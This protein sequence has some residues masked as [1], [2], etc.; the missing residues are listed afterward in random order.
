VITEQPP[1]E[2]RRFRNKA[3]L[4]CMERCAEREELKHI[5]TVEKMTGEG[6]GVDSA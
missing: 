1:R 2:E 4:M 6:R 3:K 5:W